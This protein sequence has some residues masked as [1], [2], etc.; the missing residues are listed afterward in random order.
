MSKY[1]GDV[2]NTMV[3]VEKVCSKIGAKMVITDPLKHLLTDPP[4]AL[5]KVSDASLRDNKAPIDV[6]KVGV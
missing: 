4:Y 5:E 3:R 6:Y 1:S 2:L